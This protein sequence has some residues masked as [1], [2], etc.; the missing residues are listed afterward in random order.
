MAKQQCSSYYYPLILVVTVP[1]LIV[2]TIATADARDEDVG[3]VFGEDEKT[4][5]LAT[6]YS[7]PID[8]APAVSTVITS[9]EIE[10]LG[11]RTLS[12]ALE[13]VAGLHVLSARGFFSI[14]SLRGIFSEFSPH[15]LVM[16]NGIPIT[17]GFVNTFGPLDNLPINNIERV[18]IVRGPG[19]AIYGSD[20]F[21]GVINVIT[22]TSSGLRGTELG[23]RAGYFDTV[24]AWLLHGN[25][26]GPFDVAF[27]F[28][29]W[30]TNGY[31]ATVEADAQ[32]Q[33]DAVLGTRASL[34]PGPINT[35]RDGTD[36][37]VDISTGSW[38][39]RL[40]YFGLFNAGTG[41]GVLN[42]L[43]PVGEI[44]FGQFSTDLTYGGRISEHLD[45][46]GTFAFLDTSAT[47]FQ[48]AF[49][50]GA[51]GGLFPE[52]VIDDGKVHGRQI[53][54]EAS[55]L[56]SGFRHHLVRVGA[57][58]YDT[59]VYD[60]HERRNFDA[61]TLPT[62]Q[63]TLLP[64]PTIVDI[65]PGRTG[66]PETTRQVYY[67]FLQDE[68]HLAQ[69]WSLTV[70]FRSDGYSD[71]GV[72][73]NPRAALVWHPAH[74][75]STKLLY[76]RAFRAPSFAEQFTTPSSFGGAPNPKLE[77]ETIDT[78][79]L[80]VSKWG[81][82]YHAS[83]NFYGYQTH[84][85]ITIV[86]DPTRPELL[87]F[88]NTEDQTAYGFETELSWDVT[89]AVRLKGNY[90]YHRL[91]EDTTGSLG[92]APRHLVY[93]EARWRMTPEWSFDANLKAILDRNRALGDPRP[94]IGDFTVVNLSLRRKSIGQ[95]LDLA[96]SVRNLFD[97]DARDPSTGPNALP[98]DIPL[99]G[100]NIYGEIRIH[101]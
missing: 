41:V 17:Q 36:L 20:A 59:D 27:G 6:G 86:Q 70:G 19:S 67:G 48:K 56:W 38:R 54:G 47:I 46:S 55:A 33:L 35:G 10:E 69:D 12:E 99:A 89:K 81:P 13:T 8:V 63:A 14:V 82:S 62:G 73:T 97:E 31:S 83:I 95:H 77:P 71:T 30:T 75:M 78:L 7:K 80:A 74:D 94:D 1:V 51:F 22:K 37:R 9:Q 72:T 85:P 57:G 50:P 15:T 26:W 2:A 76:G 16:L 68:W 60:I 91:T 52:G 61:L 34:A 18:E 90:A 53:R 65:A 42:A 29:G 87:R 25:R 84:N 3:L 66:L 96:F 4:V 23:G 93:A 21:S 5:S 88:E 49:P 45:L 39:L 92:V 28:S 79:E 32:T 24:D 100:R 101:F 40:G 44:D 64:L 98:F 11:V 43:D 58:L